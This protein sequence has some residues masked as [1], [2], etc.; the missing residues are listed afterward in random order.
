MSDILKAQATPHFNWYNCGTLLVTDGLADK[1]IKECLRQLN[2][3]K[4]S[5]E[6]GQKEHTEQVAPDQA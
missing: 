2:C 5:F 6:K 3:I 4:V 1:L